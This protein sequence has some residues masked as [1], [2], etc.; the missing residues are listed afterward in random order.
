MLLQEMRE[1][2]LKNLEIIQKEHI[3]SI[4][5]ITKFKESERKAIEIMTI[6]GTNI[7][8]ILNKSKIIIENLEHLQKNFESKDKNFTEFQSNHL[9]IQEKNIVC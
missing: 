4:Q 2:H 6:D 9:L 7:A 1:N 3:E 8:K 5:R